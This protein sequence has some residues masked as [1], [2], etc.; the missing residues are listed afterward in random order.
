MTSQAG[1]AHLYQSAARDGAAAATLGTGTL[2]ITT[3]GG[4]SWSAHDLGKAVTIMAVGIRTGATSADILAAIEDVSTG[5]ARSSLLY[6]TD[7][8]LTFQPVALPSS[9]GDVTSLLVLSDRIL[10]GLRYR[11][12]GLD[13]GVR[14]AGRPVTTWSE[15]C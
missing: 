9:A 1:T 7:P 13:F 2:A 5:V 8:A 14:C 12:A 6:A 3:D 10:T 11:T 4:R 15:S